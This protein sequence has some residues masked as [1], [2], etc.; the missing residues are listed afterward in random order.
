MDKTA[1]TKR[2]SAAIPN[3]LEPM[4]GTIQCT[5]AR[6]VHPNQNRHTGTMNAPKIAMGI[7]SSGLSSPLSLYLGSC[8]K[9][10]YAKNGG[11]IM[12]TPTKMPRKDKP[13][14]CSRQG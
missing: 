5:L 9:Y 2:S 11:M 8:T 14:I 10:R 4:I 3:R 7:R 6:D 12:K 13:T 1:L